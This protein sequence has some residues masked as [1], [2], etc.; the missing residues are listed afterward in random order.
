MNKLRRF[1]RSNL[2]D[3]KFI[4]QPGSFVGHKVFDLYACD[5]QNF[6]SWFHIDGIPPRDAFSCML[7]SGREFL[8][9]LWLCNFTFLLST[10]KN[11]WGKENSFIKL[12]YMHTLFL[13]WR[14]S[15]HEMFLEVC[16][17]DSRRLRRGFF[18]QV[19]IPPSNDKRKN[20]TLNFWIFWRN[21]F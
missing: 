5:S 10:F 15:V 13:N 3:W 9:T 19:F 1:V 12:G 17:V 16:T 6:W 18:G 11:F 14:I 2:S 21:F 20:T 8:R 7:K 4:I